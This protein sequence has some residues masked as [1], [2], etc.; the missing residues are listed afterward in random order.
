[1][2]VLIFG[3]TGYLGSA[4]RAEF[5]A[6]ATP[7]VDI[8]EMR[9]VA[10]VLDRVRPDVVI[11]A[12]GRTGKRN[13]DWCEDHRVETLH[14]NVTG[15]LVLLEQC[16][17]RD[18]RLVHI[19]TGCVYS[20]D[21]GGDGYGESDPPSFS[22]SFY[23]RTKSWVDQ[24]LAGFPVLILRPRMP[25]DASDHPR[26]LISKLLTYPK[27]ID[28]QNSMTCV[29]D[30]VRVTRMLIDQQA[31]GIFNVCNPGTL[32][33]LKIMEMYR[34]SVDPNHRFEVLTMAR[35]REIRQADR[36]NCLLSIS[37][38]NDRG[39]DLRSVDEA[40]NQVME[41]LKLSPSDHGT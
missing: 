24:V 7:R 41:Q 38:L 35:L 23:S 5:S 26:N 20:G 21:N 15:P 9:S 6:A 3:A 34:A 14:G 1:M 4:L 37:K 25:F 36:S 32:S 17:I 29:P 16:A 40:M 30:F 11:N 10:E 12:A 19:G 27:L 31:T 18:I 33:P 28:V 8:A 2:Q 39:I 13:I 22:G